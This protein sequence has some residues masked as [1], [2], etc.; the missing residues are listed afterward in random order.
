[1]SEF[2][3]VGLE[4]QGVPKAHEVLFFLKSYRNTLTNTVIVPIPKNKKKKHSQA[5]LSVTATTIAKKLL[6][7]KFQIHRLSVRF[8]RPNVAVIPGRANSTTLTT[9]P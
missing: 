2:A 8:R 1:M 4:Q 5:D 9:S 3:E 7:R 6:E